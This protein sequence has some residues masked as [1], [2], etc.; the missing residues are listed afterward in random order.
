M[1]LLKHE[2]SLSDTLSVL[3]AWVP[4]CQ[5]FTVSTSGKTTLILSEKAQ[6]MGWVFNRY[7]YI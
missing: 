3:L 5:I 7:I 1:P 4:I 6:L 2:L